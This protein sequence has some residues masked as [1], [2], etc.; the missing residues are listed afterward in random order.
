MET[1]KLILN[2]L[3]IIKAELNYI[4]E[5]IEDITLTQDD[6]ASLEE[7]EDDLKQGKTRAE[8]FSL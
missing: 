8:C 1:E 5:Y 6:L 2:K 3:N 7:A 4:K